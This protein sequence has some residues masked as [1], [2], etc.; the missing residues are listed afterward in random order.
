MCCCRQGGLE[1]AGLKFEALHTG[2][3]PGSICLKVEGV[4]FTGDT[5]FAGSVENRLPGCPGKLVDSLIVILL[6]PMQ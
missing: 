3:S 6:E 4:L 2:H 1:L 5:L